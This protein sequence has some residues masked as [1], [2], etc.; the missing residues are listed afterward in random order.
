MA[1]TANCDLYRAMLN[2]FL[3]TNIE[4]EEIGNIWFEQDG[5]TWHPSEAMLDVFMLYF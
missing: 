1:L 3:F 4:E 5:A 2:E